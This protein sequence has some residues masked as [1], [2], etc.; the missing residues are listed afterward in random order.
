MLD[1]SMGCTVGDWDMDGKLDVMFT[2][3]SISES[4]LDDLNQIAT[5]AGML[6]NFRGNHDKNLG[7]RLF[8]DANASNVRESG[9]G[10]G[11]F[12]FDFDNDGDLDALNGNGMDDPE[13]T[14]DDWAVNQHMKLYVNHGEDE[15]FRMVD[16]AK[17]R[18]IENTQENRGAMTFDYDND[19]DLDV[20]VV[21]HAES[22]SFYRNDGGNYYDFLR[23]K[24]YERPGGRE[25]VGATV[26]LKLNEDDEVEQIREIGS[27][28]AFLGQGE[29]TAHFGLGLRG[30]EELLHKVTVRYFTQPEEVNNTTEETKLIEHN[31]EFF[32]IQPRSTLVVYK[33]DTAESLLGKNDVSNMKTFPV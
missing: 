15:R 8:E 33:T 26:F 22:P 16:E 11:A 19:G 23:V 2:S 4:D 28:A 18:G 10:W 5:T 20:F 13:T 7:K 27:T 6:L 12:L 1:N 32:N 14:D 25:S 30:H 17:L 21:N 9:W 31:L 29:S 3:A 24:V